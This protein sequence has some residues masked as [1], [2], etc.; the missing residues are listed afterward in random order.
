MNL[1]G[2]HNF[3]TRQTE[4]SPYNHFKGTWQELI[5]L[6][7]EQWKYKVVSPHNP[8]VHLVP[9]PDKA[10]HRFYSSVVKVSD[11]TTLTAFYAPRVKGEAPFIQVLAQGEKKVP[12][13]KV[14]IVVYS[15]SVL[16]EDNDAPAPQTAEHY[17]ININAYPSEVAEP[18]RPITMARNMLNLTGGTKPEKD[19]SAE[20]FAEAIIYWSQHC[21]IEQ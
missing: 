17:I 14:D 7:T 12:A 18:M 9:M 11:D 20:E 15:H 16:A 5:A 3:A 6:T 4:D 21:R 2:L 13:K 19:Y 8:Q 1:I 10:V